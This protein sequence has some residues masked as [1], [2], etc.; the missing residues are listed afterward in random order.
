MPEAQEQTRATHTPGEWHL[1][2]IGKMY[3]QRGV[4][5]D[6]YHV[7][8]GALHTPERAEV[9]GT[10]AEANGRL[11]AAAPDLLRA[12]KI[13]LESLAPSDSAVV[14]EADLLNAIAKAEGR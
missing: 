14:A 5:R 10:N 9:E 8:F 13:V 3:P 12:C 4:E 7:G 2:H 6:K 11:I 1:A